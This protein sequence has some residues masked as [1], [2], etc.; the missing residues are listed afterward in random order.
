MRTNRGGK[1]QRVHRKEKNYTHYYN[2]GSTAGEG[3][4]EHRGGVADSWGG[5]SDAA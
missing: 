3:W 2:I 5:C 1:L 4:A